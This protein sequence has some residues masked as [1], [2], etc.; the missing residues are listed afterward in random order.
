MVHFE[1]APEKKGADRAGLASVTY[2]PGASPTEQA[3]DLA[4]EAA[5]ERDRAEKL[6]LDRKSVV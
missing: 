6:L 2:L 4:A 5:D 1:A 3:D